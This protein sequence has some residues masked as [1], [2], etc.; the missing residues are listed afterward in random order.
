LL[1]AGQCNTCGETNHVT[2]TCRHVNAVSCFV[3]GQK[4][5]W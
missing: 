1:I 5:H 2:Q 3:C 4:G